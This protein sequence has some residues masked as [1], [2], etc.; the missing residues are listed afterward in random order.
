MSELQFLSV[1]DC[2]SRDNTLREEQSG[3][4]RI[5]CE[6]E[7]RRALLLER[8]ARPPPLFE[9]S[10]T[11]RWKRC[12]KSTCRCARG[13]LHGPYAILLRCIDGERVTQL[14]DPA[15][16]PSIRKRAS[17]D[18]EWRKELRELKQTEAETRRVLHEL[19]RMVE[20][21]EDA[22]GVSGVT[23]CR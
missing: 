19:R 16:L 17:A 5:L 22:G 1:P 12:G 14:V 3:P 8:L 18:R 21:D 15:E 7:E 2:P 4:H 6:L 23:R 11:E 20:A 10:F 13:K 9:G